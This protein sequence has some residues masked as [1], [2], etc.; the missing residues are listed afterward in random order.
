MD[1]PER[2]VTENLYVIICTG[3]EA[4]FPQPGYR[5]KVQW[6]DSKFKNDWR[7]DGYNWRQ[8][9][10]KKKFLYHGEECYKYY[11]KLRIG[12][13]EDQ[14]AF[15]KDFHKIAYENP[16]FPNE[17]LICYDGDASAINPKY[18]H[19]NAKHRNKVEKPYFRTVPSVI[20]EAKERRDEPPSSVH[21]DLVRT[22]PSN[23][24]QQTVEASRDMEQIRNAQKAARRTERLTQ[25]AQYNAYELG[26]EADFLDGFQLAPDVILVSVHKGK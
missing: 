7:A 16:R 15:T 19:G 21:T 24:K 6:N 25:D 1:V 12:P 14:D 8:D 10:G 5:C 3:I 17:I 13:G 11:F 18:S 9:A 26:I 20:I 22:A 23:V 2:I 4:I